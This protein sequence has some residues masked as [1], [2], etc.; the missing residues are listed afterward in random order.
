MTRIAVV[1]PGG[2]GGFF[3][4]HATA[5]GHDVLSCARRPFTEYVIESARA[6]TRQP[7]TV[8]TDPDQVTET[9][10]WVLVG[11][12]AHQT[13]GAAGWLDRLCGPD[14]VVVALQNGVEAIDRLTPFVNGATIIAAVVYCGA[15]LPAPGHVIHSSA[16]HLFVPVQPETA[17]LAELF[18]GSSAQ[19]RPTDDYLDQ[20]WR[21]LGTNVVVN[22]I[23]ALT[24]RGINV[25]AEPM[26]AALATRVLEEAWTVARAEGAD[27]GADQIAPLIETLGSVPDGASTSMH[28]DRRAG[29]PTEWDALYGAVIRIGAT[30]GIPTPIHETLAALL[31]AGDGAHPVGTS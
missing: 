13:E 29:R 14:T 26:V 6:P 8:L 5:N 23:T 27:L 1:G 18:E 31:S 25:I 4:A 10:P 24:D 3:A 21:K 12:K 15:E 28:Q 7:A 30:H 17:R 19:I 16:G 22:G 9:Y 20:L 2:V 11:V